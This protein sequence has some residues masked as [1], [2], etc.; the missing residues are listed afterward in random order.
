VEIAC[1]AFAEIEIRKML[2]RIAVKIFFIG[3]ILCK[4]ARAK[5]AADFADLHRLGL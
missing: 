3:M 4:G 1:C 5:I 2:M